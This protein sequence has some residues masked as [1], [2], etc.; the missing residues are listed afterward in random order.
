[1][2]PEGRKSGFVSVRTILELQDN[3]FKNAQS[4]HETMQL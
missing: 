3:G 1:M 4:E 2:E